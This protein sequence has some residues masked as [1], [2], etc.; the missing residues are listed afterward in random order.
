MSPSPVR[1]TVQS[2]EDIVSR[3]RQEAFS[4]VIV[5]ISAGSTNI[6]RLAEDAGPQ[7]AARV[8]DELDTLNQLASR[9]LDEAE[10]RISAAISAEAAALRQCLDIGPAPIGSAGTPTAVVSAVPMA[11]PQPA[12]AASGAATGSSGSTFADRFRRNWD[13]VSSSGLF[14]V[15]ADGV[16]NNLV[17]SAPKIVESLKSDALSK[18]LNA[19]GLEKSGGV[20]QLSKFLTK[21]E[22]KAFL[23]TQLNEHG[24]VQWSLSQAKRKEIVVRVVAG[25]LQGL[26]K[27]SRGHILTGATASFAVIG[28]TGPAGPLVGLVAVALVSAMIS[29]LKDS[30]IRRIHSQGAITNASSHP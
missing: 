3:L 12:V 18:V 27:N 21:D 24:E 30:S 6:A 7:L 29:K 28:I 5:E 17:D 11:A 2:L 9:S 8:R 4:A 26:L 10:S 13:K 23:E 14:K 1:R 25:G 20:E 19:V 16:A 15:L 22:V